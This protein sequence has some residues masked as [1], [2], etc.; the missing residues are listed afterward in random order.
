[1]H[2]ATHFFFDQT[3]LLPMSKKAGFKSEELSDDHILM[4]K[5]AD[6]NQGAMS[7]IIDK[8][9]NGLFRFFDRSLR[10]KADAEDL[11]QRVFIRIYQS[12]SRYKP[13]A[14]FSTYLF[15]VARNLLIDE[16]KK[17]NRAQVSSYDDD[18]I[19]FNKGERDN[20]IKEWQEI[21]DV[22]MQEMP[23]YHSTAIL[24]R[25][26]RELSYRE[27]AK[28]MKVSESRVKTWIFRARVHLK[29]SLEH[30]RA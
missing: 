8:W 20:G 24:L 14:K 27:I 25:V 11:T 21:L 15:T 5:I 4:L 2:N 10:N 18:W 16:I 23:E 13:K 22:A 1:M 9:K 30:L 19:N 7:D 28:I 26:Q 3:E 17:R 12:A 29:E 6:G